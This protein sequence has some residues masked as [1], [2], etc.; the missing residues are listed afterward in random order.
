MDRKEI[1]LL[2]KLSLAELVLKANQIR[3]DYIGQRLD[4]CSITNAKSGLCTQDCKFCAQSIRHATGIPTY[5]LKSPK[6]IIA[7]AKQA[8]DIGAK[9]FGIVTSGNRLSPEELKRVCDAVAS[10]KKKLGLK[11]CA[12]LGSIDE[13][14]LQLLKVAG[15]SRYHHNLET[16][17]RYFPQ[18]ISTH[19]F[20]ERVA[21]IK[22]VKKAGL[23]V[24]S[25]GIIGLGETV[26]DR[27][28]LALWLKK[29]EVDSVPLNVLIPIKGTPLEKQKPLSGAEV[30]KTIAIFRIILKDKTIKIAAGRESLLQDF[31]A[32]A[33]MAGANGML[34]G[35]YLTVKGRDILEDQQLAREIQRLWQM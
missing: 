11:V 16:S 13:P 32:L 29:L 15:I 24:C 1:K 19:T 5:P 3:Q 14:G 31:Q 27:L 34:I 26:E 12:S 8:Q 25:G 18:I 17:P 28:E 10:I 23:E 9:R 33:F 21:T 7:G 20:E 2:E 4:L 22:A 30:I 6:E 35:G